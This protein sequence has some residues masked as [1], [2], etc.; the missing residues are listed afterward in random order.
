MNF[1]ACIFDLD[2]VIVDTAK[3]HYLAWRRL[4]REMSFD[5]SPEQN[6]RLKGVSRI[7]SLEILLEL[8]GI[9]LTDAEMI[10]AAHRKNAW[11]VDYITTLTPDEILPGAKDFLTDVRRHGIKM[12]VGSASK[13]A[14]LILHR[15]L[16]QEMFDAVIDGTKV[17]R[18]KPDPQV[19]LL[20][21]TELKVEPAACIVFEDAQAGI[22]AAKNGGMHCVG[23]GDRTILH[24]ADL[25]IRG[26]EGLDWSVLEEKL[27]H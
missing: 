12:A 5:F 22:Q 2:G 14:G 24:E 20:A 4:A 15:L 27:S 13:N 25:V 23:V 17:T 21:A 18:A 10:N 6:E 19:F 3:Y 1:A 16:L 11:Y 9:T 8:G 7:Q 26:F